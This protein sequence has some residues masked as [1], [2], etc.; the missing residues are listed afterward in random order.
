[1]QPLSLT[2][3]L[4]AI[5]NENALAVFKTIADTRGDTDILRTKLKITRKQY[6]SRIS[7]LLKAGIVKRKNGKYSPTVFGEILYD[8]AMTLEK[9][10]NNYWKLKAIDSF[11]IAPDRT[12]ELS[13]E[14]RNK[15]IDT[16]LRDD[17]KIKDILLARLVS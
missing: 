16:L 8:A 15:I 11:E 3:V 2:N 6:Y 1:M 17:Q 5:S 13:V 9:A 12:H 7:C 10:F 4:N 14:E